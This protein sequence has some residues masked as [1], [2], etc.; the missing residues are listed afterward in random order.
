MLA[1][2]QPQRRRRASALPSR[3]IRGEPVPFAFPRAPSS[4]SLS[5]PVR[6][7]ARSTCFLCFAQAGPGPASLASLL[8]D[9]GTAAAPRSLPPARTHST[10]QRPQG[11]G[12]LRRTEVVGGVALAGSAGLR[13]LEST[14]RPG[15][16]KRP[17]K[18][19]GG[20]E[21]AGSTQQGK[22]GD[23]KKC[24]MGQRSRAGHGVGGRGNNDSA[25]PLYPR[26]CCFPPEAS[27]SLH[28]LG[29][30]LFATLQTACSSL[31]SLSHLPKVTQPVSQEFEPPF[32][33]KD[34]S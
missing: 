10:E 1:S 32:N 27:L 4:A 9:K 23:L 6:A 29:S 18:E 22:R 8:A 17:R 20:E 12:T 5:R 25:R 3:D 28:E 7:S 21:R 24:A 15:A 14:A 26:R 33:Y 31:E 34:W 19:R 11:A 30:T 13:E 2:A 16:Q